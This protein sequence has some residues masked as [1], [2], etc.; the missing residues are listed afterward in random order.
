[1]T[2]SRAR[3]SRCSSLRLWRP[4]A[5]ATLL[6]APVLTT[7]SVVLA[8]PDKPAAADMQKATKLFVKA[9][10]AFKA[11]KY[12]PAL[13]GFKQSYS[14]VPS[15]N[16]HLYIARCL[17]QLGKARDA[18]IEFD[19]TAEEATAGGAKYAQTHDSAVQERDELASKLALV[20]VTVPSAE[21]GTTVR[22][23]SSDIPADHI[24]R[25][26]PV[27]SGLLEVVVQVPGKP[28]MHKSLTAGAGERRE[29]TMAAAA[30]PE[31]DKPPPTPD[32]PSDNKHVSGLLIG[33]IVVAGV[34]VAGFIMFGVEGSASKS[35]FDT[36][37][38]NCGGVAGC[39]NPVG[40]RA[41]A[42]S[43]VSS[44]KTQQAIANAGLAIGVIGVAVGVT[45][46]G[47]SFR[48][49]AADAPPATSELVV[50]PRWAGI[51]GTF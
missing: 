2:P 45:L 20:T 30:A 19:K 47:V 38:T 13:E 36:L 29:V 6:A 42:D 41:N 5:V 14:L 43:L 11:N 50:G 17:A 21:P 8:A 24:G 4:L 28:P 49:P 46:I 34:G 25:P 32:Q 23:G 10:E 22:V 31:P 27:E 35:T 44:G 18:W 48:K 3:V 40:G 9:S 1:M 15:P 39:P 26:Y 51:K 7:G 37:N 16:S 12:A 33:G